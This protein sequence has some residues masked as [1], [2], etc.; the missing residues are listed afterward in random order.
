[1]KR[2][3]GCLLLFCLLGV[4]FVSAQ[5]ITVEGNVKDENGE[6]LPGVNVVIE[7][8]SQGTVTNINGYYTLSVPDKSSKLVFSF[9]GTETKVIPVENR[10][11]IN[12]TLSQTVQE[13]ESVMVVAYGTTT[14]E[15]YTGAASV[16]DKKVL[17]NRPVTSFEKSLQGT[18]PGLMVSSSSGQPGSGSTI[19]IRGIGSLSASSEPLFVLDGIPMSGSITDIN[20]NDIESITVLKD[21]AA[22]SLYGSRAANGVVLI[23][24]KQGKSGSTKISFNSQMGVSQR[25]SKGYDL[26]NSTQFFEHSWMGLYNQALIDGE[27]I[28]DARAYAHANVK[29]TVGYNPFGVDNPLDN[30][31]QLIPGSQ[32][33]TDTDWRDEIYKNGII[34]NHNLSISGGS[35]LTKV[36]LSLGYFSDSGITLGSDFKR[37]SNKINV[38]HKINDFLE[39]GLNS[40]LS[41]S[42]TNA[43]PSGSGGANPVRSAEVINAASPVYNEFGDYEWGNKA[44]F[45][46]NPVG[47]AELDQYKYD[48]KRAVVNT[49]LNVKISP[50]FNFRTSA[51]IDNSINNGLNYYNPYHGNGAGVNGRTSTSNTDNFGWNISNIL[52]YSKATNNSY[53]EALIGQEALGQDVSVLSAGVTDFSVPGRPELVWGSKPGQPASGVYSWTMASYLS[54]IKY[55]LNDKYFFSTSARM[56]GS[57]RF[58]KNNK[59]GLFYS[60]GAGW[61]ITQEEWMP[62]FTW[63]DN[64][65]LRVSYGTSGNNNIG[66]YASLGLYGSGANYGGYPG[67]T[68]TQLANQD[69]SWEK[70]KSLNIG[71]ELNLFRKLDASIEFYNR[72]SNGLLFA[73][74]LSAG[75]GFGSIIS[76][77]GAMKN[78]GLET[79]LNYR[80]IE[81]KNVFSSI[82]FNISFNTN[83]IL[84][85]TTEQIVSGTKLLE[86]GSS[87]YQFYMREWAGVNP[88]NGRP[89]WYVNEDSDDREESGLPSSAYEDPLGSGRSVT[90]DYNDAERKRLGTSLPKAFGGL[91]YSLNYKNLELSVYFFYSLGGQVYNNDYATNMHDGTQPGSN[92]ATDALNAWTPNNRYTDVPRYVKNNMD[93]SNQMSSRFI[94]DASYLRLKNITIGYN[95]P[96]DIY[97]SLKIRNLKAFVSGENLFTLTKYKGYDPEVAINGT[98]SNT[99]PGTK[100][101][102]LGL[103]VEL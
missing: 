90:S 53:F 99:I 23:T 10:S 61:Q 16:V 44:V 46:F 7:G 19:R 39:A 60:V 96:S 73:R 86:E 88:D 50:S 67:L 75:T 48:T 98:T 76:N 24:T 43:P 95:F 38:S 32:V 6:S 12:V 74:P 83:E 18:T 22:S 9:I 14:E 78:T 1:M 71:L 5:S 57:S 92:L 40:H 70:I 21:A 34:Q 65:K 26:M 35:D 25:I 37:I 17:E 87:I 72:N 28:D 29:E 31:G 97:E 81:N 62:E 47:L 77:L 59:Y 33:L 82:G 55:D 63:L 45:D 93:E 20:P 2:L 84:E 27:S 101:I 36:F 80:L 94:E 103:K 52:T 64:A 89:M 69:L 102:T 8:T 85:L 30:N 4:N 3:I 56:D 11:V 91:N 13:L 68:P 51:G 41:Y 42:K 66:N 58:G 15:A 54:Q 79:A 100:V 49:Y